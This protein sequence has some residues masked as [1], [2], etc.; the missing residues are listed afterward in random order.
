MKTMNLRVLRRIAIED[1]G[2]A[3]VEFAIV[4][5]AFIALVFGI[6]YLGIM[7]NNKAMLQWAVEATIRKAAINT[8]VTQ[9]QLTTELNGYLST[10]GLPNATVTYNVGTGVIPVATLTGT[11]SQTYVIPYVS[12]FN[13]TY[14]ATAQVPQGSG[15]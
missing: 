10:A 2:A 12:T 11:F 14:S 3:A 6:T 4:S 8:T 13:V 7:L 1:S 9:T 5:T 15:T